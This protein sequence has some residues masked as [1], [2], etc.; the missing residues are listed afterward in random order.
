[1]KTRSELDAMT[2][3]QLRRYVIDRGLSFPYLGESKK[4]EIINKLIQF[5]AAREDETSA[6]P[7]AELPGPKHHALATPTPAPTHPLSNPAARG[8][9]IPLSNPAAPGVHIPHTTGDVDDLFSLYR[10]IVHDTAMSVDARA[11]YLTAVV[12]VDK[13]ISRRLDS[14]PNETLVALFRERL[15]AEDSQRVTVHPLAAQS[16]EEAAKEMSGAD[17]GASSDE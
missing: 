7:K 4:A 9:H 1:M 3:K 15:A 14:Q 5:R 13:R 2:V 12:R 11:G 8:V 10:R 6:P 16:F 17:L